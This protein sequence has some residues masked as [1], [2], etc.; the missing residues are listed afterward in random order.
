MGV[1]SRIKEAKK[2]IK[3]GRNIQYSRQINKKDRLE[4]GKGKIEQYR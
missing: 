4:I 2:T 1:Q 3:V